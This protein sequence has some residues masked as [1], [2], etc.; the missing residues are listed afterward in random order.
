MSSTFC[1]FTCLFFYTGPRGVY[2]P[3]S[4]KLIWN[5]NWNWSRMISWMVQR[6]P[7]L[8]DTTAARSYILPSTP[9]TFV[10]TLLSKYTHFWS[11]YCFTQEGQYTFWI[12]LSSAAVVKCDTYFYSLAIVNVTKISIQLVAPPVADCRILPDWFYALNC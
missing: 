6:L 5:W 9:A 2:P 11:V 7:K 8:H 3:L 10:F 4:S 1:V 12:L